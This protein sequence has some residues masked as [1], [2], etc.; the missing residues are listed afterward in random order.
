MPA[1]CGDIINLELVATSELFLEPVVIQLESFEI[2][3]PVEVE[4][5]YASL[6]YEITCYY[7]NDVC[8]G[9]EITY[10]LNVEDLTGGEMPVTSVELF[11]NGI[12]FYNSGL[13][14]EVFFEHVTQAMPAGCAE[15]IDVELVALNLVGEEVVVDMSLDTSEHDAPEE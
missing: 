12:S 4:V 15:L 3:E 2:P 11:V 14:S 6:L 13:I 7:V 1:N 5:L 8:Q 9:C 10:T